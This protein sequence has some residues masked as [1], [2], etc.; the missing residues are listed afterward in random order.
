MSKKIKSVTL[1]KYDIINHNK[2]GNEA[3][4]KGKK[5]SYTE[6]D[7]KGNLLL[8]IKYDDA[9]EIEEKYVYTFDEVN[10]L[11][12]EI[13]YLSENEIAEHKT[14]EYN[15]EGILVKAF[16]HYADGSKD[17]IQYHYD[18]L[19]NLNTIT[20]TDSDN[21]TE[22]KEVL[23]WQNKNL[24]KKEVYEFDELVLKES[25]THDKQGN[26]TEEIRWTPEDGNTRTEFFYNDNN[27]L[28]KNLTYN[29]E[30]KLISKTLYSYDDKG[31]LVLADYESVRSKNTTTIIYDDN[32]NA[33]EQTETNGS[34]EINN[35]AI[36]KFNDRNEVIETSV[37]IDLHGSGINQEYILNYDYEYFVD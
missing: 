14:Y 16:K 23:E 22:A 2:S 36:R 24:T 15:P 19:G 9:E 8:E 7:E 4:P 10:K 3:R 32:G 18:Q 26:R 12:E 28:I 1:Y 6:M 34:G 29:N 17:I 27:D 37:I 35:R 30:E 11:V 20:T 33:I 31:K 5:H 13:S 21:E 25:R